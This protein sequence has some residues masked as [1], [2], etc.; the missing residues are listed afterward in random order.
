VSNLHKNNTTVYNNY[1]YCDIKQNMINLRQTYKPIYIDIYN[2]NHYKDLNDLFDLIKITY[3]IA[4]YVINNTEYYKNNQYII[5][6]YIIEKDIINKDLKI[7]D[8]DDITKN[9]DV[10]V[11]NKD[12]TVENKDITVEN[13]DI[14]VENKDDITEIKD[15]IIE[16]NTFL[17]NYSDYNKAHDPPIKIIDTNF[18]NTGIFET[19]TDKIKKL[20]DFNIKTFNINFDKILHID[21]SKC[22]Q[23]NNINKAYD[24][25]IKII[26]T[27][28]SNT[29][30][31]ET[32]TEKFKRL[33][34]ETDNF[35][36]KTFNKNFNE[37]S[38]IDNSK[39][40]QKNNINNSKIHNECYIKSL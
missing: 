35:N 11:E 7:E 19:K 1:L 5:N 4:S 38:H 39:C 34:T 22:S 6:H 25:P 33:A 24:P 27:K 29:C 36:I 31:F 30:I 13:K 3:D 37:Y 16:N 21:N 23:K 9:K 15:G 17:L 40:S 10:T 28:F 2:N 12:V 32:K 18:S 14:T 20:D 8:N 26:D